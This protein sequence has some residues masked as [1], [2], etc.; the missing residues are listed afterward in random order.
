[1]RV[2]VVGHTEWI[3]FGRV[4]HVPGPGEIAHAADAWQEAGGGGAVAAVQL[5]RLAG[6]CDLFTALGADPAGAASRRRL[7]T[8]GAQVH[9]EPRRG[10][11]TRRA[12]TLVD[13]N[14]ERTITTLGERLDPLA[15]E[16]LPWDLLE[17]TDAVYVT[18]GDVGAFRYARRAR[19]MVVT[20]RAL[21]RLAESGVEADCLVGSARDPGERWEIGALPGPP[22][23]LV[24][25]EGDEGGTFETTDGERGRYAAD[26]PPGPVVDT[27][28]A[29]DTFAAG[30]TFAL[31]VGMSAEDALSFAAGCSAV[32]VS[33]R[34]PFGARIV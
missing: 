32:C 18:A 21:R 5:S 20:L 6:D 31:G 11:S 33:G 17:E 1:M 12:V 30:L 29:G 4:D 22:P 24:C 13:G 16:P 23:L 34:G 28:G 8:L 2:A 9:A 19:V 26:A 10:V 7:S 15:A 27:Y 14:G 25:T 3:E